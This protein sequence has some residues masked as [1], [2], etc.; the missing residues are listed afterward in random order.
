M[1]A[2]VA[3]TVYG[4]I[5]LVLGVA[6]LLPDAGSFFLGM[7]LAVLIGAIGPVSR[8]IWEDRQYE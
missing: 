7:F 1:Q 4:F 8:K 3:I 5:G 6:L 2:L